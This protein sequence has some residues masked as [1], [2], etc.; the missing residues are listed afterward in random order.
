M[1]P[2]VPRKIIAASIEG[3]MLNGLINLIGSHEQFSGWS[4]SPKTEE[5]RVF[6]TMFKNAEG[7]ILLGRLDR[8]VS[9]LL[10]PSTGFRRGRSLARGALDAA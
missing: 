4:S 6:V 8:E 3:A 10:S 2:P 9:P 7:I 1:S 5:I